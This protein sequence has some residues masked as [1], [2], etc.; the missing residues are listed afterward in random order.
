MTHALDALG[1]PVRRKILY[2][3]RAAPQSV[4][5]IARRFPISRPAVSRHLRVLQ[6]AGLVHAMDE[7]TRNLYTVRLQGFAPVRDFVDSF[8]GTALQRLEELSRR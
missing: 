8:W 4:G 2:A 6:E 5:D 7:G 3:L 1:N